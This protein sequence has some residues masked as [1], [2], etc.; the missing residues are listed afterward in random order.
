MGARS[1]MASCHA[2]IR[3]CLYINTLPAQLNPDV[4]SLGVCPCWR[5]VFL[6]GCHLIYVTSDCLHTILFRRK[7]LCSTNP[8]LIYHK[9]FLA[10]CH[11][12]LVHLLNHQ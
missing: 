3:L 2:V 1:A 5:V 4:I 11:T 10:A 7:I 9:P 6:G 12:M 8:Q